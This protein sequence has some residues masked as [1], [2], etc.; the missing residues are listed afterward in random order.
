[1]KRKT[2]AA[3]AIGAAA[4][5][6]G[7]APQGGPGL[8]AAVAQAVSLRPAVGKPLQEAAALIKAGKHREALAKLREADAVAG[9]TAAENNV[10]EG[11]RFSAAMGAGDADA[12]ARAFEVLRPT[13]SGAQQLQYAEAVAGTYLRANQPAKALEWANQYFAAGG[14]SAAMKTVQQQAQF[15]SGDMAAV[16]KDAL[17]AVQADEKAGRVPAQD[18]LNLLL[19]AAQKQKDAASEAFAIERLLIHHPR[20]ELWTQVLAEL[21]RRKGFS[22]R[23][24]L[25]V[26]RLKMATGNLRGAPDYMEMAQLAA[27]AGYPEEGRMVVEKGLAANV[28]GQ[29]N[30]GPRHKRLLDLM[31]QRVAEARAGQAAAV[32]AAR[33][34]KDGDALVALGLVQVLRGASADGL[35]LVQAGMS[36]GQFKRP[37]DT[38][39]LQGLAWFTAGDLDKANAAWRSVRGT[40]GAADLA[41]LWTV[42][43]R[44]VKK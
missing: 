37:D 36:K 18:R 11:T 28:L 5:V 12:M 4:L 23:L 38:R 40:D 15:K 14:T 19:Y 27:Q 21:P 13:L 31:V 16:L 41:R 6:L 43:A 8:S 3:L 42:H 30:E 32:Q 22:P 29:G 24:G 7:N 44:S 20:P 33:D 10:I 34:A 17:A 35:Q 9:R 26:Y 1:M 25:D 39:L 2:L